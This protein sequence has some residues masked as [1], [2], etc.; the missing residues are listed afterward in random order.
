M[1]MTDDEEK[2]FKAKIEA[3]SKA[4]DDEIARL[5]ADFE[6]HKT[7]PKKDE[8]QDDLLKKAAKEK[9][10][11]EAKNADTAVIERAVGFNMGLS[12][13]VTENKAMLPAEIEEIIAAAGKE[14]YETAMS[15]AGAIKSAIV[16]SYFG[17]Q[18]N[19]D[20]LTAGQKAQV[21]DFFKLTRQA[22]EEKAATLFENVF[23]PAF[24]MQKRLVKAEE[25][26]RANSGLGK[27]TKTEDAY[28][29]RVA[30]QSKNA[31]GL[32]SKK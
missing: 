8:D 20:V 19:L 7:P 16:Q 24:E 31:F 1:A 30:E 21:E 23:E 2:A 14:K 15:K 18:A 5:K 28:K 11:R 12:S 13:W 25:V 26:A 9:A 4:K 32:G 22:R 17:Q 29:S 27:A 10:D 3:D 6:K